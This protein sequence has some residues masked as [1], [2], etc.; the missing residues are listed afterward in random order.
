MLIDSHCHLDFFKTEEREKIIM[1]AFNAGVGIMQNISTRFSKSHE[2][3]DI[4]NKYDFIYTS[5]GTHPESASE[6]YITAD[7][8]IEMYNQYPNKITGIGETGLDY[9]HSVEHKD[10]QKDLFKEHIKASQETGKVLIVHTRNADDDT[11]QI[12]SEAKQEK[13]FKI[14]MHCFTGSK[15]FA[16]K[17][18]EIGAFISFSGIVTFKNAKEVQ[19]SCLITPLE[20][21]LIETDSPFVAPVPFRGKPNEPAFVKYVA[22]FICNYKKI[23]MDDFLRQTEK[24]YK[25]L[26]LS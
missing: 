20:R 13:D 9:Y 1:Q 14:L 24:N 23:N 4:A 22:D 18:L 26:F 6:D 12:L 21:M 16:L 7:K 15:E 25:F 2:I 5:I 17:L 10:L 3:I 19:E 8:L 11:L